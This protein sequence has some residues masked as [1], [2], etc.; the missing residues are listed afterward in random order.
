MAV[1]LGDLIEDLQSEV[2]P[3]GSTLVPTDDEDAWLSN[4]RNAF[5]QARLEGMLPGYQEASGSITPISPTGSDLGREL[6]QL[7]IIYAG[8]R[9]I[10]NTIR[11]INTQFRASAGPVTFE[12]QQ[13]AQVLKGILDDL[14]EEKKLILLRLS[15]VGKVPTVYIDSVIARDESLRFGDSLWVR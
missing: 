4:L 10:R 12:T 5:W 11:G 15:D 9:I 14:F 2:N 1:D 7:I 13:S 8:I 3:P 6:Q